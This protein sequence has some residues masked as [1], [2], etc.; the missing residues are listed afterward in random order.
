[1]PLDRA[2]LEILDADQC[3]GLLRTVLVGRVA[4]SPGGIPT[5]LPVNF[6]LLDTSVVFR[7]G[8]GTKLDAAIR[9]AVVAFEADA[10]HSLFETGWSVVVAGVAEE[11]R[12]LTKIDR[13]TQMGL[14][15]WAPG[16]RSHLIKINPTIVSGRRIMGD[17]QV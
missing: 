7:T 6:A 14:R 4:V 2:G 13:V 11:V 9:N 15:P 12:D 17:R 16:S 3:L 5:I 8:D 1:M 10:I